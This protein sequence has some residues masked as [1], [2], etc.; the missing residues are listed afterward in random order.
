MHMRWSKMPRRWH[1]TP[2]A[3]REQLTVNLLLGTSFAVA[4]ILAMITLSL[5]LYA[6]PNCSAGIL[7]RA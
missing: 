7:P 1:R 3:C 2:Q 6:S 5:S 4:S